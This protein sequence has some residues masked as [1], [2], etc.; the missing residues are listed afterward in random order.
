[1]IGNLETGGLKILRSWLQS[2]GLYGAIVISDEQQLVAQQCGGAYL[3]LCAQAM[4]PIG[5]KP[6]S[7]LLITQ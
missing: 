6:E 2:P 5:H 4:F 3:T 7:V 1:M